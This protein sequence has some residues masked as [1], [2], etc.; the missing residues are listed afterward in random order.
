MSC[1]DEPGIRRH[2]CGFIRYPALCYTAPSHREVVHAKC[3]SAG[4]A[5]RICVLHCTWRDSSAALHLRARSKAI[6][7]A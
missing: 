1:L 4:R 3:Q 2:S 6:D 5:A 7:I